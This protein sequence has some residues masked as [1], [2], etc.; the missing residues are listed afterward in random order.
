MQHLLVNLDEE[1]MVPRPSDLDKDRSSKSGESTQRPGNLM[2]AIHKNL[3]HKIVGED[4]VN[5]QMINVTLKSTQATKKANQFMLVALDQ[6]LDQTHIINSQRMQELTHSQACLDP[7]SEKACV[8]LALRQDEL[9][10]SC[11]HYKKKDHQIEN[12]KS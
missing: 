7:D 3:S 4:D 8:T 9:D 11:A 12:L 2:R 6:H 1:T 10:T 5:G